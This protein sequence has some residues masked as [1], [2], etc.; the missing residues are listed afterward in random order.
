MDQHESNPDWI[1]AGQESDME[2]MF[3][4]DVWHKL[5]GEKVAAHAFGKVAEVGTVLVDPP[6]THSRPIFR[7][8]YRAPG[9]PTDPRNDKAHALE[10]GMNL[11]K[12]PIR[13]VDYRPLREWLAK[14]IN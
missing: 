9:Y 14:G 11:I 3:H 8:V 7:K 12:Q 5:L 2:F 10:S 4:P 6:K 13:T 1:D